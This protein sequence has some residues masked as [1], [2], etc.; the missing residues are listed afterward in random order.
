V[1]VWTEDRS[2]K[3]YDFARSFRQVM[4]WLGRIPH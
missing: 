1:K 2:V 4:K 3:E